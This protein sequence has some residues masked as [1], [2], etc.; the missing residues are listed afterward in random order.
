M[1]LG[2]SRCALVAR[3]ERVGGDEGDRMGV[4]GAIKRRPLE[5]V[6]FGWVDRR[7]ISPDGIRWTVAHFGKINEEYIKFK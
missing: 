1:G 3:V 4:G 5:E 6:R 7:P 2:W